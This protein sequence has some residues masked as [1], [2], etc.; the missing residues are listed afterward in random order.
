[1]VETEFLGT[2]YC[3][4]IISLWI[5]QAKVAS[6]V[7]EEHPK[8]LVE[9]KPPAPTQPEYVIPDNSYQAETSNDNTVLEGMKVARSESGDDP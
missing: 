2:C 5:S 6:V 7:T 8:P 1:M 4:A 3:H 9:V